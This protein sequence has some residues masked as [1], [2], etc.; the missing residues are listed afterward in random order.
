MKTLI[1]VDFQKDFVNK[2]GSLYVAGAEYAEVNIVDY[3]NKHSSELCEVIF[4]V[5]WHTENHCSFKKNGGTWPMHCIQFTEG[6]G[7]SDNIMKT[8]IF[9]NLPVKV[10]KKGNCD[11][12]EEYGAFQYMNLNDYNNHINVYNEANESI[13]IKSSDIVVCGIAGDYCVYE[14]L[15]NLIRHNIDENMNL[16]IEVLRDCIVSIDGGTK[17]DNFI[18]ENNL[19]TINKF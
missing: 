19:Q 4:T 5:D 14:T 16:N 2:N 1:I 15:S 6:A 11:D 8:C 13:Y 9:N 3:I 18:K 12:I 7:I 10:F 17:L